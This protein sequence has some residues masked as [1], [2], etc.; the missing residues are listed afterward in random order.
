LCRGI[1]DIMV[2]NGSSS[3][4]PWKL[5]RDMVVRP[6]IFTDRSVIRRV[7]A[8]PPIVLGASTALLLQIAHPKVAQGVADHSDFASDP[9]PRLLGTL[10]Y[11]G[12][13]TFGTKEEAHKVAWSVMRTHDRITGPGYSAH[14]PELQCWVNATLFQTAREMHERTVGSLPPEEMARYYEEFCSY[15]MLL[16][17]P[18]EALPADITAFD[19]YW[20]E[21]VASLDVTD[22][23]RRLAVPILYPPVAPRLTWPLAA[24]LRLLT[25]GML[26]AP[27][28]AGYALPWTPGR[29]RALRLVL[30]AMKV[31]MRMTPGAVRRWPMRASVP[32][33]RRYRWRR[34]EGRALDA[35][36]SEVARRDRDTNVGRLRGPRG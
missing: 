36:P 23:A 9:L 27:V 14:D 2:T 25:V 7:A 4:T 8:E 26:P 35:R 28:R 33:F 6:G 17:C 24:F 5:V 16:G 1:R 29:R 15:A 3:L 13:V 34:Y 32:L 10:D 18:R 11:L 22:I 21:M 31:A 20:A 19:D 30:G 12:M